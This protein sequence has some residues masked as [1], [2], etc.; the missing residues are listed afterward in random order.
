MIP[1]NKNLY[2]NMAISD[3]PKQFRFPF[4]D[5]LERQN[6]IKCDL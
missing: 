3:T 1:K 4:K 2:Q 5:L 6:F